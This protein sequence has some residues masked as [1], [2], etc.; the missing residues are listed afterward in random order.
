MKCALCQGDSFE[1]LSHVDAKTSQ[2]LK[3]SL[4]INCGLIQQNPIPSDQELKEYYSLNYR[5]DYKN[6]YTPKP[7]HIYRAG[8]AALQR[9][10]ILKG[11]GIESG[12]LLDIGAGGGE[13]VYLAGLK[14]YDSQGIDPN[15]G[16][17]E[18]AKSEYNC[19]LTTGELNGIQGKYDIITMF[20]V[21]EHLPCPLG[22]FE[23]LYHLLNHN[24][25]LAVEVPWIEA[26]DASP[27]NIFFKAHI[28]YFSTDSL[29]ACAS[30]YFDVIKVDTSN[31]LSI[32]FKARETVSDVK[33]PSTESIHKLRERLKN[34]G[35]IEY[36]FKGR[37][38]QKPL[39]NIFRGLE[40]S[41][42]KNQRPKEILDN[43]LRKA[44]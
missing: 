4:C 28:F 3:V 31:N 30:K 2:K 8:K 40:E 16:Y 32:L 35:W 1:D 22:A 42:A 10:E 20:H 11:E 24:G 6:S 13:F 21:L 5:V 27:H 19:K 38:L 34:K 43:L 15:I 25:T 23:K 7:K 33:L 18:Y 9:L 12:K 29:I 36:L 37:G 14:G 44:G 41:R 26:N 39:I 17:S